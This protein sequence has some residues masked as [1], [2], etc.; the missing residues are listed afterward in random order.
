MKTIILSLFILGSIWTLQA[1]EPKDKHGAWK[2]NKE[3]DENGNLIRYDSVY[4]WSAD[5]AVA[6]YDQ[7]MLD[8][9]FGEIPGILEP[10]SRDMAEF[11]DND[12]FF[13]QIFGSKGN[14]E[15]YSQPFSMKEFE[16]LL[17]SDS[18]DLDEDEIDKMLE[19]MDRLRLEVIKQL[20]GQPKVPEEKRD[21]IR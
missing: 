4:S 3:Y 6:P 7:E 20:R 1:Q 8:S 10:I 21:T 5:G 15:L 9:L 12:P 13:S 11:F 17:R 2:V 14:P 16:D 18:L 19:E